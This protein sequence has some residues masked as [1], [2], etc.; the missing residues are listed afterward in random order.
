MF[1]SEWFCG[2]LPYGLTEKNE[3]VIIKCTFNFTTLDTVTISQFCCEIHFLSTTVYGILCY[4][5][6]A[7]LWWQYKDHLWLGYFYNISLYRYKYKCRKLFVYGKCFEIHQIW[8]YTFS[9]I[10]NYN[11]LDFFKEIVVF[12]IMF[13]NSYNLA[14]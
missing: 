2:C 5:G 8:Q 4:I 9:K 3:L 11:I 14:L 13:W 6:S 10:F 12:S 1:I 7:Y